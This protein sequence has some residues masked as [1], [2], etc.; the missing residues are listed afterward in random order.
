[1]SRTWGEVLNEIKQQINDLDLLF[2][3][4]E[5]VLLNWNS[6]VLEYA[7]ETKFLTRLRN[8][9]IQSDKIT[10]ALPSDFLGLIAIGLKDSSGDLQ[11]LSYTPLFGRDRDSV[12]STGYFFDGIDTVVI[13]E[14]QDT[15]VT[16]VL[17]YFAQPTIIADETDL[18]VL[19]KDIPPEHFDG[20][21]WGVVARLYE[22]RRDFDDAAI[23]ERRYQTK[24]REAIKIEAVKLG[25]KRI[26]M[27]FQFPND[28]R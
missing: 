2:T 9:T 10:V 16:I 6:V 14:E 11:T 26:N 19:I 23:A 3:T 7:V 20:I 28:R 5:L 12:S 1:M 24:K 15:D 8:L 13:T 4:A 22:K 25:P 21:I 17:Y 27:D 18:E